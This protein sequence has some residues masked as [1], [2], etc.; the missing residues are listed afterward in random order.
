M[1]EDEG[2]L[3][4][5]ARRK[6]QVRGGTAAAESPQPDLP[7]RRET[8][9]E[10]LQPDPLPQ[11]E[12]E[13]GSSVAPPAG[14]GTEGEGPAVTQ[15]PLDAPRPPTLDDVAHLSRSSDFSRFIAPGVDE[16]VKRAAMKKLFSDPHFNVMDGL[17]VYI[18]DYNITTPLT[19]AD[20]RKMAQS[21]F[22][23]LFEQ[24][25]PPAP[26]EAMANPDGAAAPTVS[27]SH[28]A[29][30]PEPE[31]PSS[32]AVPPDE[33]TDLRLQ[34]DDAAGRGGAEPRARPER[35]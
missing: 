14:R 15:A 25:E 6:A 12:R 4:R 21:Q 13:K 27:Q 16:T 29:G 24:D 26:K 33:N 35:G 22:L 23:R 2:F 7:P 30:P 20:L 8:E 19:E 1:S 34:P 17:D 3:S 11:R 31:T 9:K 10:G 32:S 5:W 18:E 28:V